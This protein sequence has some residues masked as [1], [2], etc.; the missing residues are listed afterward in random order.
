MSEIELQNTINET[1]NSTEQ[2][3]SYAAKMYDNSLYIDDEIETILDQ[4]LGQL[5]P[6][7][8][9]ANVQDKVPLCLKQPETPELLHSL[10]YDD[11]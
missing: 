8:Y 9:T 4:D 3:S 11:G 6:N 1:I 7:K 2:N 5:G 10:L